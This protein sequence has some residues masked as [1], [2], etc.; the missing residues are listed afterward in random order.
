MTEQEK[1]MM[2]A[3]L[4]SFDDRGITTPPPFTSLRTAA[5]WEEVQ[6]LVITWTGSFNSIQRQIVD[7]AQEECLVIIMCTDSNVVKSN[8]TSNGI[9][10]VNIDYIE[11]GWNSIWVRDYGANTVYVNDVDSLILVDWIYN[12]P[13]PL[14]DVIPDAYAAHLGVELYSM[15]ANPYTGCCLRVATGCLTAVVRHF[16]SELILDENDGTGDSCLIIISYIIL[17]QN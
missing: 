14:D 16:S 15:S 7:A 2:D 10:D 17:S 11:V 6:A 1:G 5:E 4:Q 12:R 3:Y 9:P 13:R 8:L